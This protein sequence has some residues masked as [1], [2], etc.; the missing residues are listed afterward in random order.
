MIRWVLLV[1]SGL[2]LAAALGLAVPASAGTVWLTI[3]VCAPHPL[4]VEGDICELRYKQPFPDDALCER[5][6]D[7]DE[8]GSADQQW[9]KLANRLV[10]PGHHLEI[11]CPFRGYLVEPVAEGVQ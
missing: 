10:L 4:R 2:A 11:R 6:I 1:A 5:A 8:D 7:R 9:I 3:E